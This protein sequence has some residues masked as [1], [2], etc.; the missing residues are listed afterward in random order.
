MANSNQPAG[1]R[2]RLSRRKFVGSVG[3]AAAGAVIL[4][5]V[6][7]LAAEVEGPVV[8]AA[9]DPRF[10]RMFQLPAF[11]NPTLDGGPRTR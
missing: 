11:A 4:S 8:S 10:S 3:A 9:P 5:D 7:A 1:R 6:E 2:A